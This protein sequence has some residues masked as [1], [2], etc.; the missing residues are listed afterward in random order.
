MFEHSTYVIAAYAAA[1]IILAWCAVAPVI[2]GRAI[3]SALI[4][5]LARKPE[6]EGP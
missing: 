5:A 3:R 6:V 2:K 1:T 4:R